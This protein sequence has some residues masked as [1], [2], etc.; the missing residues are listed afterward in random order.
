MC[1][2]PSCTS[3][4]VDTHDPGATPLSILIGHE[5]DVFTQIFGEFATINA[6]AGQVY[7]TT[8][9]IDANK[10]PISEPIRVTIP[11]H[12]TIAGT[13]ASGAVATIVWRLGY[14]NV[15][16]R[17]QFLWE[18]DGEEGSIRLESDGLGLTTMNP[19]V[20]LN[21][22]KVEVE[23]AE[24]QGLGILVAAW[25]AYADGREEQYATIHDAVRNHERLSVISKSLKEG[26]TV[27]MNEVLLT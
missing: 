3:S 14:K 21:G 18:I 25:E 22:Q 15:P 12:Y 11:D 19:T 13:L 7:P 20:Y 4:A 6:T 10:I 8:T 23:G 1:Y 5:L 16:G 24:T 26:R 2:P 9:I 27:A 17:R